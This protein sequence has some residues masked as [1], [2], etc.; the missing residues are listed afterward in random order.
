MRNFPKIVCDA[1]KTVKLVGIDPANIQQATNAMVTRGLGMASDW[2]LGHKEYYLDGLGSGYQVGE[3]VAITVP[4]IITPEDQVDLTAALVT[5]DGEDEIVVEA[6]SLKDFI[7]GSIVGSEAIRA[8]VEA[9]L[10]VKLDIEQTQSDEPE[11]RV[12]VKGKGKSKA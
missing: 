1:I 12:V 9:D 7:I 2:V 10:G 8:E 11:H 6:E 3:D 5:P 4:E